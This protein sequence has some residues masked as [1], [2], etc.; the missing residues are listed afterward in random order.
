M[1]NWCNNT[2]TLEHTDPAMIERAKTAFAAGT[3]LNEFIPC[4][5]ALID[6]VSGFVPEQEKLEAQ[7]AA[8]RER[9]GYSTWYDHN[10]NKWGTKWDVGGGDGSLQDIEGGVI[11][12]F[13]SA[14]SPPIAAYALLQEQGFEILAM[15]Y[16]PGM[17]F[18]GRWYNGDDDYYDYGGMTADEIEDTLPPELDEAFGISQSVS[19]WEQEQAE[20]NEE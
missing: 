20:E 4:P 7:Q 15:Y 16:E 14:W 1:P 3:F 8:N 6:T 19:E 17:C 13:D 5:Q 18:A 12:T 2:V 11:I 9:Y 10:I